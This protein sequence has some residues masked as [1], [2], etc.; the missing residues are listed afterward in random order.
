MILRY[1]NVVFTGL[2]INLHLELNFIK[3]W[4][5]AFIFIG[6]EPFII[7]KHT[8]FVNIGERCNVAGSRKFAKLIKNDKY[9]VSMFVC[10]SVYI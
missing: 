5:L 4:S 3:I 6:L 1:L 8:N 10:L 9:D 7:S 2:K